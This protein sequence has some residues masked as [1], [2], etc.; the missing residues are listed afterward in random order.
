MKKNVLTYTAVLLLL[1]Q[2]LSGCVMISPSG[3]TETTT[4]FWNPT[5]SPSNPSNVC[6][7]KEDH[8]D[9]NENG[10]CDTC[11]ADVTVTLDLYAINDLHGKFDDS[12]AQGGVDELTTYL[13]T[14]IQNNEATILLSS[15]D[16]WQGSSESNVTHG[17]IIT[18]WMNDLG[19]ASMTLGNH[20]FDWGE[21]RVKENVAIA[22]F[23]LLAIN[24]YERDTNERA[25]YCQPSVLVERGN[26]TI[27]IIGAIG[28][29]YSS[30]SSDQVEGIYFK[31]GAQLTALVTEEA[32][33]LR[34][35]GADYIVYSLHDGHG[36][37]S[38]STKDIASSA[39]SS[40]YDPSLSRDGHVD[41]V[42]EGHTHRSY[43]LRDTYGVYHLQ[44]GG[45]NKDGITHAEVEIN[46]VNDT[47]SVSTAEQVKHTSYA[48]LADDAI[49]EALLLKYDSLIAPT[50]RV[51]GYNPRYRDSDELCDLAAR[52]YYEIGVQ[53]WGENYAIVS[54][55]G[56]FQARSPYNL[57]TGDVTYSDVQMIFPFDN[58]IML[59]SV[60][61]S[62]LRSKFLNSS[63]SY[64]IYC[65]E[66]GQSIKNN[67]NA[68]NPNAT[69][70]V[71][72]DSYTAQY[73]PNGLTIVAT[74]APDI[75]ARDL[76]AE[77]IEGGGF[78][79]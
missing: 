72:V 40:Y 74:L 35:N 76:I 51:L 62:K 73:A 70:Y 55:G 8:V 53:T 36:S 41:M 15:G 50:R 29:C 1:V 27:G 26:L 47:S 9:Q 39:L 16:M 48:S 37:S 2:L 59:C 10:I 23:P 57:Y 30:I 43:V 60:S 71:I 54:G 56:F 21:E 58:P 20:E 33:R 52:L 7:T 46:F 22:E 31:T 14:S 13:R 79:N 44:G 17:A 24:V 3:E 77:Y 34:E 67:F 25:D 42:F 28:D 6:K 64:H 49:V 38:S 11:R 66:Y 19:F 63:G 61:G 5:P 69:Y 75:F 18:D 12:D 32:K 65:G 78:E 4:A 68:I 45:D